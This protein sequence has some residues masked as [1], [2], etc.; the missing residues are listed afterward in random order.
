MGDRREQAW[1]PVD[2]AVVDGTEVGG[3]GRGKDH[4]GVTS[5]RDQRWRLKGMA[6]VLGL[7]V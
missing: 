4:L 5:F 6:K 7:D 2:V 3:R 1:R